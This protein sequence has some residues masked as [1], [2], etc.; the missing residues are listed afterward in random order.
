MSCVFDGDEDVDLESRKDGKSYSFNVSNFIYWLYNSYN[1]YID[2][3]D[4]DYET[5]CEKRNL[6]AAFCKLIVYK[7]FDTE[8]AAP[9]FANYLKVFDRSLEIY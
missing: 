6:L 8:L 3:P 9:V 4:S 7:I 1:L 2:V 5:F